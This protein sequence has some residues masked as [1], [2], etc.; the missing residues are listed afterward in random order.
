M[1]HIKIK[2]VSADNITITYF[3]DPTTNYV[4]KMTMSGNM[5][6]QTMEVVTTPTDYRK[7]DQGLVLPYITEV[8]YGGQFSLVLKI[9]KLE[10]NKPVDPVIF[11]KGNMSL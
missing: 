6:G 9:K 8:N 4:I 11:E 2:L 7:T 10:F 5:M 3:I 1:T